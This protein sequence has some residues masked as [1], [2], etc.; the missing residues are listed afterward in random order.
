M[1]DSDLET[2][3]KQEEA[4]SPSLLPVG[5]LSKWHIIHVHSRVSCINHFCSNKGSKTLVIEICTVFFID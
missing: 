4:Q 2:P 5:I 3:G 1:T